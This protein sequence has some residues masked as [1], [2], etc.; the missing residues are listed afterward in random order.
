MG[1]IKES[2]HLRWFNPLEIRK[3]IKFTVK[4]QYFILLKKK[5]K[6]R[7]HTHTQ[8]VFQV[9]SLSDFDFLLFLSPYRTHTTNTINL[10]IS[11][12]LSFREQTYTWQGITLLLGSFFLHQFEGYNRYFFLFYCFFSLFLVIVPFATYS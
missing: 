11:I 9:L 8:I 3:W 4:C 12:T 7:T 10:Y 6:T 5:T 1:Q 2:G